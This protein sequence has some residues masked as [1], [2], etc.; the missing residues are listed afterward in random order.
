[1]SGEESI[2]LHLSAERG[3]VRLAFHSAEKLEYG[4]GLRTPGDLVEVVASL[5]AAGQV[6]F[7]TVPPEHL[8]A[9]LDGMIRRVDEAKAAGLARKH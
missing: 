9:M 8:R 5:L 1:M 6:A 4:L 3:A 2:C 7:G